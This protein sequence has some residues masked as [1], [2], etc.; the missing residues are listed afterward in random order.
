MSYRHEFERWIA[1]P[2]F[3]RVRNDGISINKDLKMS[4]ESA[5]QGF[6]NPRYSPPKDK[7]REK[8]KKQRLAQALRENLKK[9]KEQVRGR[10]K[11]QPIKK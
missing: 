9:R 2:C 4:K 5:P 6:N 8:V 3:H 1:S 7:E 11:P 10:E